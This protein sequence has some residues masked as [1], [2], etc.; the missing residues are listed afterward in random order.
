MSLNYGII[1]TI[2]LFYPIIK[3]SM[4]IAIILGV[5]I[6]SII[7]LLN[8][9]AM[10]YI[11]LVLCILGVGLIIYYYFG[12]II[13]FKF[14][15]PLNNIYFYFFNSIICLI[16]STI[17]F[18]KNKY[19]TINYIFYCLIIINLSYSL[20]MTHYLYNYTLVVI[21]NIFPMI[22]F[23]NIIYICYYLFLIY[24]IGREKIWNKKG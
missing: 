12:D 19:K 20:F 14:K 7:Y 5:V 10:K 13:S 17:M 1:D 23:G 11:S 2:K 24:L 9:K 4:F 21:G 8:N 15:N 16:I 3:S 6:L 22:K 18:F